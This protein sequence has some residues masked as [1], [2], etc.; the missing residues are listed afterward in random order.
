MAETPILVAVTGGLQDQCGFRDEAGQL[1]GLDHFNKEWGSNADGKYKI[2]GEWAF[3]VFPATRTLV[4]SPATPYI[5]EDN[6]RWEDAADRLLEIYNMSKEERHRRGKL[7]REF[8]MGEA[9]MTS[10]YMCNKLINDIELTFNTFKPQPR[11]TLLK[12]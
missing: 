8:M 5:F 3:P 4:G 7:G 9:N 6:T 2:Y 12:V 10:E 11:Y 1:V